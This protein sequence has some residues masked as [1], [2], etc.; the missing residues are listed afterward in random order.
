MGTLDNYKNIGL[1]L[2][3]GGIR[4][5][6][7]HAGVIKY[8]AEINKLEHIAHVSSVSGGTLLIGLVFHLS[9]YT[10]PSSQSYTD[11]I[12]YKLREIFFSKSLQSDAIKKM[13]FSPINWLHLFSRSNILAKSIYS[14]WEVKEKIDKLPSY[15]IWSING[16]T[17]ETG[18]RFRLKQSQM[19]DYE[20]GYASTNSFLLAK[21]M[22][23]S[24]AFPF[25]FGPLSINADQFDWK[26]KK[27][28]NSSAQLVPIVPEFKTIHIY[29][30]GLYDNLGIEPFFDIGKQQIKSSAGIGSIILS[31]AGAPYSK[32]MIPSIFRPFG[33]LSRIIGVTMEQSRALRVRSY[34]NFI[35][36]NYGSGLYLQIGVDPRKLLNQYQPKEHN[37]NWG[38]SSWLSQD[39]IL[40]TK[41]YKT[42]LRK[43]QHSDFDLIAQ[44]GYETAKVN[45]ILF[46]K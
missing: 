33:R 30:G 5:A 12:F 38:E 28:W 18:K 14:V 23:L 6:A 45:S 10:W 11:N 15:P 24:A 13:I 46:D 42:T 26:K 40:Y 39:K 7:Y 36:N 1:A 37:T 20:L 17:S 8:L 41:N 27:S 35:T 9:G 25:G 22:A 44:H 29:D 19:G 34:V 16:T 21:A 31:D 4:A 3:G 43:L 32:E 2:S